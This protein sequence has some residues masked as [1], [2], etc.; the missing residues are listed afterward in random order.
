VAWKSS[1]SLPSPSLLPVPRWCR[2][3][4][5]CLLPAAGGCVVCRMHERRDV[6]PCRCWSAALVQQKPTSDAF[7]TARWPSSYHCSDTHQRTNR[8][9][10]GCSFRHALAA[11]TVSPSVAHRTSLSTDLN[12]WSCTDFTATATLLQCICCATAWCCF[13]A[14]VLLL[15]LLLAAFERRPSLVRGWTACCCCCCCRRRTLFPALSG[16]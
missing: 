9:H 12:G 13:I 5:R 15:L 11:Q 6:C 1:S 2:L 3:L 7:G 16:C 4:L 10:L 8:Q 14:L